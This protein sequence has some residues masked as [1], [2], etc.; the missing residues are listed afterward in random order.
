MLNLRP[1][2]DASMGWSHPPPSGDCL[3]G[4]VKGEG[5]GPDII[6]HT[7]RVL[8][9]ACSGIHF[10]IR[11]CVGD[12]IGKAAL[13]ES[14]GLLTE[15]IKEFFQGVFA[16]GGVV[17]CGPA[18]G[19]FVYELRSHF[20][21][22]CKIVPIRPLVRTAD[23]G[24]LKRAALQDVDFILVRENVG[25]IYMGR[26]REERQGDQV[27]ASQAFEYRSSQVERI[28]RTAARL[29][30]GRRGKLTLV[31]KTEGMPAISRLW[32][33]TL[34]E[35]N[36]KAGI[37]T[38][39]LEADNAAFQLINAARNFDVVVTSNMLGDILGDLCALLLGSRGM[40]FSGN[41]GPDRRA[42]YQTAHGAA[43]DLVG[44]NSANPVGQILSLVMLLRFS[45]GL[46][47]LA[48]RIE[49]AVA[50]ILQAG[51]RTADL[52][53]PGC[54]LVGTKELAERIADAVH[55]LKPE[56]AS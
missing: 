14:G 31:L 44:S 4:V 34:E 46:N 16:Q 27:V 3:I 19:R 25:G 33:N 45:Y 36:G 54:K 26:W 37:Q 55:S 50:Q 18:G 22:F 47:D 41:F 13:R 6:E 1:L 48:D 49:A 39:L 32:M 12:N 23:I 28:L 38:E 40:S 35:V 8:E 17:L 9:A 5:I 42:V 43:Y 2:F 52:F 21:L 11:T 10:R 15:G 51:W 53:L 7:M 24:V 29:A 30:Q 20:D 56:A